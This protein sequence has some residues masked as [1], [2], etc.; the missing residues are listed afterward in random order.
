MN[1]DTEERTCKYIISEGTMSS[2]KK[3]KCTECGDTFDWLQMD[4]YPNRFNY[5]RNCGARVTGFIEKDTEYTKDKD[6]VNK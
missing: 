1:R 3:Y 5:C 2:S 4:F 6:K